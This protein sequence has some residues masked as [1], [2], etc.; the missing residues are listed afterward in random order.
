[1]AGGRPT[2][3]KEEYCE[4]I[5]DYFKTCEEFPTLAGFC[6]KIGICKQ[7]MHTWAKQHS[8]FL[9]AIRKTKAMQEQKLVAGGLSE[10]YNASFARF[11][12]MNY[13]GMTEQTDLNVTSKLDKN[14]IESANPDKLKDMVES[15]LK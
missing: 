9:D 3:Y 10:K 15:Y 2:D 1:M 11:V 6:A 14:E 4:E 13:V 7:T 12:A 5:I 8:E